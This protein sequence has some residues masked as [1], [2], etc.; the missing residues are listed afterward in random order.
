MAQI[1]HAEGDS[2]PTSTHRPQRISGLQGGIGDNIFKALE[3]TARV[4]EGNLYKEGM[5]DQLPIH[6]TPHPRQPSKKRTSPAPSPPKKKSRKKIKVPVVQE[7][8]VEPPLHPN[9][10]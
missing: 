3:D 9:E 10:P 2:S 1:N 4:S 7:V 5:E 6:P 8:I